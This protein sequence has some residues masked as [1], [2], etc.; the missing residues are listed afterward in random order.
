[1]TLGKTPGTGQEAHPMQDW[2][3]TQLAGGFPALSGA[4]LS[5]SIPVK[6]ELLNDLI[7]RALG[8]PAEAPSGTAF[9]WRRIAPFIRKATV[10]AEAGVVTLHIDLS[11]T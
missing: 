7:A 9:D 6:E 11:I 5:G 4:R 1:M 10:R 3:I 8:D 2:F